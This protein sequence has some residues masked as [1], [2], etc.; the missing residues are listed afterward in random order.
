MIKLKFW[1]QDVI[2]F[3]TIP[4]LYGVIP[5]PKPAKKFLPDWFKRLPPTVDNLPKDQ[6][7]QNP[8]SAKKCLPMLDAMSLGFIIPLAADTGI[9]TNHDCSSIEV[10]NPPGLKTAGIPLCCG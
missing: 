1:E 9:I 5:E 3:Y 6:F 10:T 8:M 7:G 4:E 2:Q